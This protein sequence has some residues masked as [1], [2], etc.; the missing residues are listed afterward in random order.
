MKLN[1]ILKIHLNLSDLRVM[2]ALFYPFLKG[3][4]LVCD[5]KEKLLN[6]YACSTESISLRLISYSELNVE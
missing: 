5:E 6:H 1:Y 4:T 3:S 2:K